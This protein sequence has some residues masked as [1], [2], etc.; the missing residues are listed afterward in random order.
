[1]L[2]LLAYEYE[3]E[4]VQRIYIVI[5]SE[6]SYQL[7]MFSSTVILYIYIDVHGNHFSKTMN[8]WH[9]LIISPPIPPNRETDAINVH[10][11][12]VAY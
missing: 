4:C 9:I 7:K 5:E 1:M 12:N 10:I 3:C 2:V 11:H 6:L 8:E